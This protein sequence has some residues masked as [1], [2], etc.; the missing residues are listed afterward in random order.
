[1]S[2]D[3]QELV[4]NI[5]TN[6]DDILSLDKKL[7]QLRTEIEEKLQSSEADHLSYLM[8]EVNQAIS[9]IKPIVNLASEEAL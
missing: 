7:K 6:S 2:T 1:M 3:T 9:A 8:N 4:D 5:D